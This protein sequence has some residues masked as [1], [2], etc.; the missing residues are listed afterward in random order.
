MRFMDTV[1][2]PQFLPI[3][4]F[5][6]SGMFVEYRQNI[7]WFF[8]LNRGAFSSDC[9]MVVPGLGFRRRVLIDLDSASLH[10]G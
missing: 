10:P 5:T 4:H 7:K 3:R 1:S 9:P 6:D 8:L 2:T